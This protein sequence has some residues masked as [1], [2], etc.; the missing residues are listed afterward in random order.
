MFDLVILVL[1]SLPC[2]LHIG[3]V[4][5]VLNIGIPAYIVDFILCQLLKQ[6]LQNYF[7]DCAALK[8]H[9]IIEHILYT[10]RLFIPTLVAGFDFSGYSL[11]FVKKV[12][13]PLLR[14]TERNLCPQKFIYSHC[15][16]SSFCFNTDNPQIIFSR[17]C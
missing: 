17:F 8:G 15:T 9:K 11:L 1:Q 14:V 13:K 4:R 5:A 10:A 3:K 12:E 7:T 2:L 6:R 16:F